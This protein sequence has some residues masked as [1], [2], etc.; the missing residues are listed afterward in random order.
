MFYNG[1]IL[2]KKHLIL[3]TAIVVAGNA[4]AMSWKESF[5]NTWKNVSDKVLETCTT[6]ATTVTEKYNNLTDSQKRLAK[7]GAAATAATIVVATGVYVYNTYFANNAVTPEV[8]E[9]AKSAEDTV[10]VEETPVVTEVVE[11]T[12]AKAKRQVRKPAAAKRSVRPA[13]RKGGCANGR[14]GRR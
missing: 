5:S 2:M 12:P 11:A 7:Y 4:S 9:A 13:V 14:C 1:G 10:V 3:A 6:G 8:T